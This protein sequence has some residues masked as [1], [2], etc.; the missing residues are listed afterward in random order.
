MESVGHDGHPEQHTRHDGHTRRVQRGEGAIDAVHQADRSCLIGRAGRH[1]SHGG[2]D[3]L[4]VLGTHRSGQFARRVLVRRSLTGTLHD[5]LH[6]DGF[7]TGQRMQAGQQRRHGGFG[8]VV[9]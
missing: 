4:S 3:W 8:P 2:E 9:G 5:P 6:P 1:P 7:A